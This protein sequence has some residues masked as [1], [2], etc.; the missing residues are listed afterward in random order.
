[1]PA[2]QRCRCRRRKGIPGRR[3]LGLRREPLTPLPYQLEAGVVECKE[4]VDHALAVGLP[5]SL[6]RRE[7][8]ILVHRRHIQLIHPQELHA[9][10]NHAH[11][12]REA[13]VLESDDKIPGPFVFEFDAYLAGALDAGARQA[14][15]YERVVNVLPALNLGVSLVLH[16]RGH[17]L[18]AF[19]VHLERQ[20]AMR[21][22]IDQ[23]HSEHGVVD[24]GLANGGQPHTRL[25]P[26][27]RGGHSGRL[28]DEYPRR[29]VSERNAKVAAGGAGQLDHSGPLR[30]LGV[31]L[32]EAAVPVLV[33]L[34]I[35]VLR[36]L[37][38]GSEAA[39]VVELRVLAARAGLEARDRNAVIVV[40]GVANVGDSGQVDGDVIEAAG[41]KDIDNDAVVVL[42]ID[43]VGR[44]DHVTDLP[45]GQVL[46]RI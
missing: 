32:L 28:D 30:C 36:E 33:C 13:I 2:L 3:H 22:G 27:R 21:P 19:M 46:V 11:L 42:G 16:L 37:V 10:L 29:R 45:R 4:E 38:R 8:L 5:G 1:M 40:A 24:L 23:R 34:L 25:D 18:V 14:G 43:A 12:L 44:R 9:E 35:P 15:V 17:R 31:H 20:L 41:W 39:D 7:H 6:N 26:Q